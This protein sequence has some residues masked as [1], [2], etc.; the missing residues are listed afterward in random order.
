MGRGI[1]LK[2]LQAASA[3]L[4]DAVIDPAVWAE[5]MEGIATA[6]G[7]RGAAL[8]QSDARTP[9]IPRTAGVDEYFRSYFNEGWHARDVRANRG[10]PL[11]LRG[12]TAIIDQDIVTPDEMRSMGLYAESL[13]P[14]GLGWFCAIGFWSGTA[15]WGLTVQRAWR[16]GPFEEE[17]KRVLGQLSQRLSEAATLS[18]AVGWTALT[19][20][21]NVLDLVQLPTLALDR[22]G[23]VLEANAAATRL[24]DDEVRI[25]GG[26]LLLRDR[27]ARAALDALLDRLRA[28]SD[29]AAT[30][31]EPIVVRRTDRRPLIIRVLP[32][33]GAARTPFLGARVLL[34]F[35]DLEAQ[36]L[37]DGV[38]VAQA[39][40]LS[41]A[42]TRLLLLLATGI[43]PRQAAEQ[44]GVTFET[45]RVH[46]KSLF[47]KTGTHRQSELVVLIARAW[48]NA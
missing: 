18:R 23:S 34:V 5:I 26:R 42:E 7:A 15:L 13:I 41:P 14:R 12:E 43:S 8:L 36:R 31:C 2:R 9:D 20:V 11:L 30:P 37:P 33:D 46:L 45:V 21:T 38:S 4:G 1:D 47:A 27:Q 17:D 16:D 24:F 29:R 10:V 28:T 32:V 22:S 25:R 6:A 48:P 44:L 19:G 40:G 39:F 3:R 35:S